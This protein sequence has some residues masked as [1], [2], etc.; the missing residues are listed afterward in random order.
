MDPNAVIDHMFYLLTH[1]GKR[2]DIKECLDTLYDWLCAGGF[3][4][5]FD[6]VLYSEKHPDMW[7]KQPNILVF[8][9]PQTSYHIQVCTDGRE[10]WELVKYN[11]RGATERSFKFAAP[12]E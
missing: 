3:A 8:H 7:A 5:E 10:G 11:S 6:G 4:P 1:G 2:S 12:E 9:F